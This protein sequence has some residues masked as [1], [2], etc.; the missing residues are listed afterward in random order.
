[1]A[2]SNEITS[3]MLQYA[4]EVRNDL[5]MLAYQSMDVMNDVTFYPDVK[6]TIVLS[7]LEVDDIVKPFTS[8]FSPTNDAFRFVPNELTV[9]V[10]K[11]DLLLD[12]EKYRQTYLA[13]FMGKGV[14]RTPDDLPFEKYVWESIFAKFGEQLNDETAW[15]GVYD[16]AGSDAV[17]VADGFGTQL[18]SKLTATTVTP[19]VTGAITS[20][21]A[22]AK[23]KLL[24][25]TIPNK[26]RK[27]SWNWTLFCSNTDYEAY[28][29]NLETL[30]VNT[31]RGDDML[32]PMFVRGTRGMVTLKPVSWITDRRLLLTPKSNII[33][34]ADAIT[35]DMAK[36]NIVQD[37]W[38]AKVGI[39]AA[40]GFGFR[41]DPL[42]I[43]NEQS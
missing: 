43:C 18:E 28:E 4:Q 29:D 26:M 33:M 17:D 42:I 2:Q 9:K 31:G 3:E 11:A 16:A 23:F 32:A 38:T 34:G 22:V 5:L 7:T 41:Y 20:S 10:A 6:N 39:A 21:N 13:Q 15:D 25:R 24:A 14:S 27:K 36:L 30:N 19:T 37:V 1:M 40:L 8:T 35:G 12:P